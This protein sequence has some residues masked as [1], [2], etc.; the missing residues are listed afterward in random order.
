MVQLNLNLTHACR[1]MRVPAHFTR[2]KSIIWHVSPLLHADLSCTLVRLNTRDTLDVHFT[3]KFVT[4]AR[5]I[6]LA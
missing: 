4:S 5:L 6:N 1:H 3:S 2:V